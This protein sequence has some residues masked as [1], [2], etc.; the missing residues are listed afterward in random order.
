METKELL[1]INAKD[2]A[3]TEDRMEQIKEPFK[4]LAN[5]FKK[6]IP[7]LS[8]ILKEQEITDI[9]VMKAKSLKLAISKVRIET[10]K[11]KDVEK[12]SALQIWNA[13]QKC[14]N[15]I[16]DVVQEKENE[17]DK[18]V[19]HFENLEIERKKELRLERIFL[20]KDYD[21]ENLEELN[22]S[23]MNDLVFNNF[24][25]WCKETFENKKAEE[26]RLEEERLKK[27]EDDRIE[28]E[29]I[30]KENEELKKQAQKAQKEILDNKKS[31]FKSVVSTSKKSEIDIN[32]DRK[33]K[34][35][36]YIKYRD[37]IDF[38]KLENI[39][40]KIIFYKKVWEFII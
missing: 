7:E 28:N 39:D 17:L 11:V 20:L 34:E 14:H 10:K 6:F 15:L 35:A 38:D 16:V 19:K 21:V 31:G 18:I 22:L 26:K 30:R 23:D 36:D 4:P 40:W 33:K 9:L 13:I 27:I 32:T 24:L 5:K 2:F 37:S 12:K 8:E 3:L 29:R 1:N 25:K